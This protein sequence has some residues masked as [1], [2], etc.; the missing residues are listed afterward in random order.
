MNWSNKPSNLSQ[1][2]DLPNW[3]QSR[4][5]Y[6]SIC[7]IWAKNCFLFLSYEICQYLLHSM[8]LATADWDISHITLNNIL[9]SLDLI[10]LICT[11]E[12][13]LVHDDIT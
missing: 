7:Y 9:I 13:W 1:E 8:S 5:V 3:T 10:F 4:S 12:K 2:E 6:Q 11:K